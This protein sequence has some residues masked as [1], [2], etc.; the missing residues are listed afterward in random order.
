MF[1][2]DFSAANG[3]VHLGDEP[4]ILHCNHYNTFLQRTILDP[5]YVD[6]RP[7]LID[8]ATEVAHAQLSALFASAKV[9][10]LSERLQV[11][12]DL[13]RFCGFGR[14]DLSGLT[15][16]GG[17]V[18]ET[19]SHYSIAWKN[20]FGPAREPMAFF[21]AGFIAGAL[22][23][24][25]DAAPGDF[26]ARQVACIAQGAVANRFEV[27]ASK[28]RQIYG[29]RRWAPPPA[30]IPARTQATPVDENAIVGALAQMPIA[31]NEEGLI[32]AF[33]VVLTRM[34]ADY[35]NRISFEFENQ[36]EKATGEKS[37][38]ALLLVEAGHNCAFNTFG[39]IMKSDEWAGLIQPM[40]QTREDWVH[41]IVA[42]VNALGWGI[43]RVQE[44]VPNQRLVVRID[45][46]YEANG[47]MAMY[48]ESSTP[49]SYLATGGA[50]G[51][52]NLIYHMD[53]TQKPVLSEEYYEKAF[54]AAGAF[55]ATQTRCRTMGAGFDEFVVERG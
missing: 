50:A 35:Y 52:M 12:A 23:A 19:T 18:T 39:G 33:G 45:N 44:L 16:A 3:T 15:A 20:K 29:H 31:G 40:C 47:F 8:A 48:K 6:C 24:A 26:Q 32:P 42:V 4:M 27:V 49:R 9:K 28:G 38:G 10:G 46:G 25:L 54:T 55:S 30:S 34:C 5:D 22:A 13:F 17:S 11:A 37:L 7:I 51:I 43:W 1:T 14:L 21:D 36:I 2:L 53:I 41:G